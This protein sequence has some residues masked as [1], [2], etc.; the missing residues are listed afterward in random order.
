MMEDTGAYCLN[1]ESFVYTYEDSSKKI[2]CWSCEEETIFATVVREEDTLEFNNL[3]IWVTLM[4]GRKVKRVCWISTGSKSVMHTLW[5]EIY[6]KKAKDDKRKVSNY[7]QMGYLRNLSLDKD[8]AESKAKAFADEHNFKYI[9]VRSKP[10]Y[11]K[12][13]HFESYN[14]KFK[15]K[16]KRRYNEDGSEAEPKEF[17]V[18]E[19]TPEFWDAWKKDKEGM[20]EAGFSVSKYDD[21][22][23]LGRGQHVA[24][25]YVFFH[26]GGN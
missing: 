3:P 22:R 20:K 21:P 2:R 18:G 24:V 7:F 13:G 26:P 12:A 17:Y 4:D 5:Y 16:R 14:I 25:W 15:H 23:L 19:A 1:C 8:E 9:G 11:G 6:I 10:L